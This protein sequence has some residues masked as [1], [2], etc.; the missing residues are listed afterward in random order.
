MTPQHGGVSN[1]SGCQCRCR[2]LWRQ[3]VLRFFGPSVSMICFLGSGCVK[4]MFFWH[5]AE[6]S[7]CRCYYFQRQSPKNQDASGGSLLPGPPKLRGGLSPLDP[8]H[9]LGSAALELFALPWN[10]LAAPQT[11]LQLGGAAR[12]P[13]HHLLSSLRV[14]RVVSLRSC[15]LFSLLSHP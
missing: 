3:P 13:L 14:L 11:S 9:F 2:D 10:G 12:K 6:V 1:A 8:A 15:L 7:P 5:Q 4:I